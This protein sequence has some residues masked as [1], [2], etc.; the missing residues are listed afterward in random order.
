MLLLWQAGPPALNATSNIHSYFNFNLA[1]KEAHLSSLMTSGSMPGGGY[2]GS[3]SPD[4]GTSD[5]TP[6]Y[7]QV[8][9]H[10][11]HIPITSAAAAHH[12]HALQRYVSYPGDVQQSAPRSY[13]DSAPRSSYHDNSKF[14]VE[15]VKLSAEYMVPSRV[16]AE[17]GPTTP[18]GKRLPIFNQL[19]DPVC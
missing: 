5:W 18:N 8:P 1:L 14:A 19:S 7:L 15:S 17:E 12:H 6:E 13:H 16:I 2:P 10:S 11:A 4:S 3:S 9:P